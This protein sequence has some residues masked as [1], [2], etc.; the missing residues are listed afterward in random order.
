VVASNKV[1]ISLRDFQQVCL[2]RAEVSQELQDCNQVA[3]EWPHQR[4]RLADFLGLSPERHPVKSAC[5]E[6]VANRDQGLLCLLCNGVL[7]CCS[8]AHVGM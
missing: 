1:R 5:R 6:V 3:K 7:L 8:D 2:V 4:P